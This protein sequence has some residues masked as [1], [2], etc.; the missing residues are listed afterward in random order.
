M[1]FFIFTEINTPLVFVEQCWQYLFLGLIQGLTEFLP[2]SSTAHLFVLPLLLGWD[3]P[4]VSV[5]ASLQLGSII[6]VITYFRSDL[7][8]LGRAMSK[9]LYQNHWKDPSANLLLSIFLGTLPIIAFG[10]IVKLFWLDYESSFVRSIPSIAIVSILMGILLYLAEIVGMRLKTIEN[11][12]I[13]DGI[14]IGFSQCLALIPGVS[15]SGITITTALMAGYER[16]SAARFSFLLG[17][18]AISIAGLVEL[19]EAFA[20]FELAHAFPL[21]LGISAS[22]LSSF[23]AIDFLMKF[24][25]K[26]SMMIFSVY[27]LLF[28]IL[29][30][31]WYY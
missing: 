13:S 5:T 10:M 21:L 6:A 1:Y 7:S 15:R 4:G 14:L 30:L 2:I 29:L 23:F 8:H 25:Q 17:I 22:A 24:L 31:G 18:P 26:Q 20:S 16:K 3:A 28:G 27:R 19:K 9:A 11:L 12:K